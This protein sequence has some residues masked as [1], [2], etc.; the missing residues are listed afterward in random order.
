MTTGWLKYIPVAR[1]D[2]CENKITSK[3]QSGGSIMPIRKPQ[4]NHR[5]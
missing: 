4:E 2:R 1:V 3:N 5:K